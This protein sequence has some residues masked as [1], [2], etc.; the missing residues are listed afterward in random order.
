V[1]AFFGKIS[2]VLAASPYITFHL[3]IEL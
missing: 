2:V 1:S 3:I